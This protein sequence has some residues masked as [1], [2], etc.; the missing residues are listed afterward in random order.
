MEMIDFAGMALVGHVR[1][2]F[3]RRLKGHAAPLALVQAQIRAAARLARRKRIAE[4]LADYLVSD[5]ADI[6]GE[7]G[8]RPFVDRRAHW[9]EYVDREAS[10]FGTA[11]ETRW[12][13]MCYSDRR[14]VAGYQLDAPHV[15]PAGSVRDTYIAGERPASR[16]M[17]RGD[18]SA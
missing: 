5:D 14:G 13:L 3:S 17:F 4:A 1:T 6:V 7:Q 11:R 2:V 8:E 15:I 16:V 9:L 18:T 10:G 12:Y